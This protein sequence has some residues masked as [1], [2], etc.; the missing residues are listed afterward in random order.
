MKRFF[1]GLLIILSIPVIVY[2]DDTEIYGVS[3]ATVKPNVLLILDNSGSMMDEAVMGDPYDPAIEYPVANS[4]EGSNKPCNTNT[5]Y[6]Y[7]AMGIEGMWVNHIALSSVKE[8]CKTTLSTLGQYQGRLSGTSGSCT[9]G[10]N[11]TYATGNWINWLTTEGQSLPKIQIAKKVLRDL[12]NST[13]GVKFGLMIFNNNDGGYLAFPVSDM[14]TGTN[15]DNLLNTIGDPVDL[16][17]LCD[18]TGTNNDLKLCAP[19]SGTW[20][21]L[22]ETLYEAMRYYS[23]GLIEFGVGAGSYTSPIEY[24][25]QKNYVVLITDGMST[26]DINSI[27]ETICNEGDCDG[28]GFEPAN[29]PDKNYTFC[30]V[31]CDGSDYLDDVA[32]YLSITDLLTDN[33]DE[34]ETIGTQN[35]ITYTIGFGLSGGDS[36]AIKLLNETIINGGSGRTEAYFAG[37]TQDLS[38]A[39]AEITGEILSDNT[40]FV[41]PVVPV[42][43]ENKTYSG[44]SVYIGF[45]K[46][47][48][49]P[50]WS[51]NLKKYGIDLNN[52]VVTDKDG[53]TAIDS[54]GNFLEQSISYWA[55]TADGGIVEAGGVGQILL[56]RESERNIYTFLG[57]DSETHK[58]LTHDD[59]KFTTTNTLITSSILSTADDTEKDKVINFIHGYDSFG[60]SPSAKR[61]W[62]LGDILHSR[63]TVIHYST[64]R[65]VIYVGANDGML[66]AFEDSDGE[67]LWGFIPPD[68]LNTLKSLTILNITST[69]PYYVDGSPRAFIIDANNNGTI[70]SD[71]GDKAIL[72][73][74]ERRGGSSYY[75]IDVTDPDSPAYLWRIGTA[76]D[77]PVIGSVWSSSEFGQS[78]SEPEIVKMVIGGETKY[79][80]FIGGG[81]DKDN[82]DALPPLSLED[83]Q[84]PVGRAVFAVDVLTGEK[85]WEY[86]Y[87]TSEEDNDPDGSKPDMEYSIPSSVSTI[88]TDGNGY[89]DRVYVGD[90]AGQIWRFDVGNNS[91]TNWTGKIIFKSNPGADN[92]S[93]RKIFYPPDYVQ[94]IGYDVLFFGTGDREHPTNE[95]VV[96]RLYAVKDNNNISTPL[97]ESNLVNVTEDLLQSSSTTESEIN[98][99]LSELASNKGW[100]IKLDEEAGEKVLSPAS[101]FAKVAYYTTYSPTGDISLD[102]CQANRGTARVYAVDYLTGEAVFNFDTTNDSGYSTETNTRALGNEGEVLKRSDRFDAIG[103]G[104][105]SG[106][107]I[108][109]NEDG[110]SALIGVGGGLEIPEVQTGRTAIRLYWIEK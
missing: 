11:R 85:L 107:V 3:T 70:S 91:T 104:I 42:S 88:D 13:V 96:D 97:T 19:G 15:K 29:D 37:D 5:V 9:S 20:T 47:D 81:Y 92:S 103:S 58:E 68:L 41:A 66:H 17:N 82:E 52:G 94:E 99:I 108:I 54:E 101:V 38:E 10:L 48:A 21:P 34:S 59:N 12:I 30:G 50:F 64:S 45:F 69:H 23:G 22:G 4:C 84:D 72:V 39:L 14:E 102:A 36:S 6:R 73:T 31:S 110:E 16:A 100:Y 77:D 44:D 28:D 78:W 106:A 86:S 25:C 26:K 80:F 27:L 51:G 53:N 57:T 76:I 74:G 24:A 109:I 8:T 90:M 83:R 32:K 7:V 95:D 93:G 62:I 87:T 79:V 49:T 46:P 65:S 67:E 75:A 33:P 1:I 89:A 40:S 56:N 2:A 98:D 71:E 105:P 43:P 35:V 60:S 61:E 55:T 18:D 63:P